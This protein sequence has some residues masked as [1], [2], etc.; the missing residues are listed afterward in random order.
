MSKQTE[1]HAKK[2]KKN[3]ENLRNFPKAAEAGW[4][5]EPASGAHAFHTLPYRFSCLPVELYQL[6]IAAPAGITQGNFKTVDEVIHLFVPSQA[7]PR[8]VLKPT[9]EPLLTLSNAHIHYN[10]PL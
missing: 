7:S 10:Q 1:S 6:S 2:K 9:P 5:A 4:K 3:T 8:A